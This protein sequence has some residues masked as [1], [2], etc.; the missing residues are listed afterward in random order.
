MWMPTCRRPQ[1]YQD[2]LVRKAVPPRR[3]VRVK[4]EEYAS[5]DVTDEDAPTAE[6]TQGTGASQ[7]ATLTLSQLRDIAEKRDLS[8]EDLLSA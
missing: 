2:L 7:V 8:L 1:A 5:T 4:L 6:E 3:S